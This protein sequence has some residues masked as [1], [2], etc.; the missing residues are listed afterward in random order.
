VLTTLTNQVLMTLR[1]NEGLIPCIVLLT[2]N[3][4]MCI[5]Q[6][7][8]FFLWKPNKPNSTITVGTM[9]TLVMTSV[10]TFAVLTMVTGYPE[11]AGCDVVT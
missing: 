8:I 2:S 3:D 6:I 9:K 1:A 7:L 11:K 5:T 10:T 4:L